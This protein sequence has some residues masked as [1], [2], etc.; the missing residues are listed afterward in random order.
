M[1]AQTQLSAERWHFVS[2]AWFSV[3]FLNYVVTQLASY[4]FISIHEH[5]MSLHDFTLASA[6]QPDLEQDSQTAQENI[7]NL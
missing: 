5:V 7:F 2:A 1:R 6:L 4:T 3:V